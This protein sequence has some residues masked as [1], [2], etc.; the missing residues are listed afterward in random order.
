MTADPTSDD[1]RKALD[2]LGTDPREGEDVDAG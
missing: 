2:V 1:V